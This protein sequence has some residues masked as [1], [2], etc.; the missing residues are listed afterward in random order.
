MPKDADKPAPERGTAWLDKSLIAMAKV[1]ATHHPELTIS[2]VL[3][4]A[5]TKELTRRYRRTL[6]EMHGAVVHGENGGG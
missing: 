3:E 1:I 4:A 2:D 6:D 5:L